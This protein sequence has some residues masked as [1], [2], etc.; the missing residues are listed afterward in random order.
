MPSPKATPEK[1][2]GFTADE[3]AAMKDHAHDQKKAAA[4]RGASRAEKAAADE[5]DVLAKIAEM[6]GADRALAER[7]HEIVRTA[8][9]DLAPKLWYGMPAYARDGKVVC[10]FQSAEKFKSRYAT[11]GFSDQAA[12]D[13]GTVWATAYAIRELTP[14]D[15]ELITALLKKAVA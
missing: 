11:L 5:Q 12:L 1:Y 2:D 9:P 7:I 14:A 15:E 13:D 3:R 10:H 8:A 4:R 6:P